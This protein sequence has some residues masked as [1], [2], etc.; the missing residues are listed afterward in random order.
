[1]SWGYDEWLTDRKY[2]REWM[3]SNA[4]ARLAAQILRTPADA[5]EATV[6]VLDE[7]FGDAP[8]ALPAGLA[9]YVRRDVATVVAWLRAR[10]AAASR[11]QGVRFSSLA[12]TLSDGAP[13]AMSLALVDGEVDPAKE[14]FEDVSW[15]DD[16]DVNL[17]FLDDFS[18]VLE[19]LGEDLRRDADYIVPLAY[20]TFVI[21]DA[22]RATPGLT[23]PGTAFLV[24]YSGGDSLLL[25]PRALEPNET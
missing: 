10:L 12:C 1:M 2:R 22:L 9:S 4:L 24:S 14:W 21:R 3:R 11:E 18:Q 25:T 15:R 7:V 8:P 17:A 13:Y 20:S 6:C 5:R 23:T 16:E 19:P